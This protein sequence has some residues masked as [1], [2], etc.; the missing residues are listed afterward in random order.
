[1]YDDDNLIEEEV[2]V[3]AGSKTVLFEGSY[4]IEVPPEMRAIVIM[5]NA[6]VDEA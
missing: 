4:L 6:N 2:S 1:M 5:E 3:K